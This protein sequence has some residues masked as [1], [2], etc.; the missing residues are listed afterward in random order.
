MSDAV[1]TPMAVATGVVVI[2]VAIAVVLVV[3]IVTLSMRGRQ[4]RGATRRAEDRQELAGAN[5]RAARAER[6][7]DVAEE[8]AQQPEDRDR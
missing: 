5:E 3:L 2:V 1:L 8:H 4:K 6:D 7:R